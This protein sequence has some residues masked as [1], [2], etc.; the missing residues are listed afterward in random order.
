MR[1]KSENIFDTNGKMTLRWIA[2][3]TL[4]GVNLI[5]WW[6]NTL[7]DT[8]ADTTR[9]KI[10]QML[11]APIRAKWGTIERIRLVNRQSDITIIP[12]SQNVY[13][14][15]M[16]DGGITEYH[17]DIPFLHPWTWTITKLDVDWGTCIWESELIFSKW[18]IHIPKKWMDFCR[19]QDPCYTCDNPRD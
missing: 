10:I 11:E 12:E 8:L 14:V 9:G 2:F 5:V 17:I 15:T 6:T 7:S 18:E 19:V 13:R 3:T 1:E 4:V 16:P